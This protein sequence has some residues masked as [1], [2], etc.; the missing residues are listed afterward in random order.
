M[1]GLLT[2]KGNVVGH[3]T[4]VRAARKFRKNILAV[5]VVRISD[6]EKIVTKWRPEAIT[7]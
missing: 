4:L 7:N 3:M 5:A 2:M 6:G 1:Y